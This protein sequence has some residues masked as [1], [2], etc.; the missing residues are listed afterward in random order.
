MKSSSELIDTSSDSEPAHAFKPV[1]RRVA[2]MWNIVFAYLFIALVLVRNLILV[3][4]YLHYLSAAS[5]GAWRGTGQVL[6]YL[7]TDFGLLAVLLQQV[8]VAYGKADRQRLERLGG[9]GLAISM[10]LMVFCTGVGL[11]LSPIVPRFYRTLSVIEASQLTKTLILASIANGGYLLALAAVGMLRSLQRPF[12]SGLMRV[13]SEAVGVVV[14]VV[15]MKHGWGLPSLGWGLLAR[16]LLAASVNLFWFLWLWIR[17]FKIGFS[18]STTD[19]RSLTKLSTYQFVTYL[20]GGLKDSVDPFL[21]G[22]IQKP[23]I[24]FSYGATV[25]AS[26]LVRNQLVN[27]LSIAMLPSLSHLHGEGRKEHYKRVVILVFH[28]QAIVGSIGMAGVMVFNKPFVTLLLGQDYYAGSAVTILITI[29]SLLYLVTIL[30]YEVLYSMG[31]FWQLA[32]VVWLDMAIRVPLTV[33]LVYFFGAWGAALAAIIGQAVAWNGL[34]LTLVIRQLGMNR[35]ELR[36]LARDTLKIVLAPLLLAVGFWWLGGRLDANRMEMLR[37][38]GHKIQ[39]WLL[40]ASRIGIFLA[41]EAAL[42]YFIAPYLVQLILR[43]GRIAPVGAFPVMPAEP[44]APPP[45]VPGGG[46]R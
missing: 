5:L 39:G 7:M 1:S 4:F 10:A 41:L 31:Q 26:D 18:W 20:A 40:F 6:G 9:T 22:V 32:K 38:T 30:A 25:Q 33:V 37:D 28:L 8:A 46:D 36:G 3:P 24:A 2:T 35:E 17:E 44:D 29:Y 27:Q 34:L 23:E 43:R 14:T 16:T 13:L 19:A 42:A 21:I 45:D 12:L 11:I 15:L